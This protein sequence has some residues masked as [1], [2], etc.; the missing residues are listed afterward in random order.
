MDIITL[1]DSRHAVFDINQILTETIEARR[2]N[3]QLLKGIYKFHERLKKHSFGAVTHYRKVT[4]TVM[5][6]NKSG[7]ISVQPEAV[8]RR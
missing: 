6:R 5:T 3:S 2:N 4:N 1:E 7:N 8:K